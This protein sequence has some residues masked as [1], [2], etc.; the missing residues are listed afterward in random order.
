MKAWHESI[1][2]SIFPPS[3]KHHSEN[4]I[5]QYFLW[6]RSWKFLTFFIISH[7][8]HIKIEIGN[9]GESKREIFSYQQRHHSQSYS[10]K[11]ERKKSF[12]ENSTH[13]HKWW[14]LITFPCHLNY[15]PFMQKIKNRHTMPHKGEREEVKRERNVKEM[16]IAYLHA[17][18]IKSPQIC[19]LKGRDW[20]S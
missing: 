9:G 13:T 18:L 8:S 15:V 5:S 4:L 19:F 7:S 3:L 17:S 16:K 11:K 10:I 12:D 14:N 6:R 2:K 20:P 1:I